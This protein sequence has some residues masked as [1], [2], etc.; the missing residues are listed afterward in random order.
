MMKENHTA[1]QPR[2]KQPPQPLKTHDINDLVEAQVGHR[3]WR[4]MDQTWIKIRDQINDV[5]WM[6]GGFQVRTQV[7]HQVDQ[8][9]NQVRDQMTSSRGF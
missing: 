8:V 6:R 5:V 9:Q 3:I 7:R 4:H 1:S 2:I